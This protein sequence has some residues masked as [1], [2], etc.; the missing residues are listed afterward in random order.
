[1]AANKSTDRRDL[2]ILAVLIGTLILAI[3]IDGPAPVIW[4]GAVAAAWALRTRSVR[5][6][7][8]RREEV[9]RI[10]EVETLVGQGQSADQ[11]RDEAIAQARTNLATAHQGL[12]ELLLDR[13]APMWV[14][15]LEG[16]LDAFRPTGQAVHDAAVARGIAEFSQGVVVQVQ[17]GRRGNLMRGAATAFGVLS[18]DD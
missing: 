18:E 3:K 1:M 11:L 10:N 5:K 14:N 17:R 15:D 4:L 8:E 16:K 6:R 12:D 13:T 2:A 7:A 9:R